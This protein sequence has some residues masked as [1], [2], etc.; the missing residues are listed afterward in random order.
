MSGHKRS[1][2]EKLQKEGK[3]IVKFS[4]TDSPSSSKSSRPYKLLSVGE[5]QNLKCGEELIVYDGNDY[6]LSWKNAK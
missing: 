4:Q 1:D 6:V 5:L 3:I 2:G